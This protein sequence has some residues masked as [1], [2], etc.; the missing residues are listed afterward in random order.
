MDIADLFTDQNLVLKIQTRLP[1]LFYLAELENSRAGK[2]GMEVGSARERILVALL[3]YKFG[4]ENVETDLPITKSEVDVRLVG[5]P[6]SIKTV[7]ARKLGGLKISWTVDP[8]QAL[9][10]SLDYS[11]TCDMLLAQINWEG[12]GGFFLIP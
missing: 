11:P 8:E 4:R 3:I 12:K 5:R 10:F 1:E 7:T 9:R 2:V 6:V